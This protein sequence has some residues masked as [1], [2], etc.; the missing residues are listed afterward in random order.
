MEQ[1]G[2]LFALVRDIDRVIASGE[3][4][5]PAQRTHLDQSRRAIVELLES[6]ELSDDRR[7]PIA[8]LT[9]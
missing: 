7:P 3:P 6:G 5:S 2:H 4:L 1:N 8:A 9:R